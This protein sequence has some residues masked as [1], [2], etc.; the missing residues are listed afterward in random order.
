MST[1][2][3][4]KVSELLI[5]LIS[6]LVICISMIYY[7]IVTRPESVPVYIYANRES[8]LEPSRSHLLE[9]ISIEAKSYLNLA[10]STIRMVSKLQEE[11][12]KEPE[13]EPPLE[14][15]A[16]YDSYV[17][18]ITSTL[19]PDV[20]PELVRAIIYT[21]SRYDPTKI[22]SRTGCK[23]LTGISPKWHTKRAESLG[24]TDL[25][26][27]YGNILVC[28]DLLHDLYQS[29]SKNYALDLY[30]GGYPYANKYSGKLSPHTITIN[31]TIQGLQDGS[32][33]P[34][35]G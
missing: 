2:V 6:L 11:L 29:Y 7:G 13:P 32:I 23:G 8:K 34:G 25:L 20:D 22:N 26:D 27:P 28:C 24:V 31:N 18:E 9:T 14:G 19:Y 30:A 1:K 16:L 35:E 33:I 5:V 4:Q 21:E 15:A 10:A 3:T 17:Y 12:I